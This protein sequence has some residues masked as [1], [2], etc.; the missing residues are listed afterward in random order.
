MST[1]HGSSAVM[2]FGDELSFTVAQPPARAVLAA[3]ERH[4]SGDDE[5]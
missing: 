4:E 5:H 3:R 1:T 2:P